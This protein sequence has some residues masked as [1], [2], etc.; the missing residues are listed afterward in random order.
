MSTSDEQ[1]RPHVPRFGDWNNKGDDAPYTAAFDKARKS[2]LKDGVKILNPNDHQEN[3]EACT[4]VEKE[5][6]KDELVMKMKLPIVA[7]E[8]RK[9]SSESET[10]A[11]RPSH[12]RRLSH[13]RR[14]SDESEL[15]V[16]SEKP[17]PK[18]GD[19]DESDLK[20]GEDFTYKFNKLKEEKKN[21]SEMFSAAL[22]SGSNNGVNA[23][24]HEKSFSISKICC[25]HIFPRGR[26]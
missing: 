19:W 20:S 11:L 12:S 3:P 4:I 23:R 1:K 10:I 5:R 25:F 6:V 13:H 22:S 21:I 26:A 7:E 16:C 18:F 2:K 15:S 24:N 17:I 9:C 14:K 8:N